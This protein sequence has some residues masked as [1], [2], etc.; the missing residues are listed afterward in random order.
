M[1]AWT[2]ISSKSI[3]FFS[4]FLLEFGL[5]R[6]TSLQFILNHEAGFYKPTIPQSPPSLLQDYS[7]CNNARSEF[8]HEFCS[9][10]WS[11]W[12]VP[13]KWSPQWGFKLTTFQL[14]VFCLNHETT[15]TRLSPFFHPQNVCSFKNF[16]VQRKVAFMI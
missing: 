7:I 8:F 4:F 3:L 16:R 10:L 14:W 15:A 13:E 6:L 12:M 11:K 5:S 1:S 9:K 2:P